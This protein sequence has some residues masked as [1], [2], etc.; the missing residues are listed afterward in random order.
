MLLLVSIWLPCPRAWLLLMKD[1]KSLTAR[2]ESWQVGS[3]SG[4]GYLRALRLKR[5]RLETA[6]P[7]RC[8]RLRG[9]ADLLAFQLAQRHDELAKLGLFELRFDF[10]LKLNE[11][12]L[13]FRIDMALLLKWAIR[14]RY[15][16]TL[17]RSLFDLVDVPLPL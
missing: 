15:D 3:W 14:Q 11:L 4:C 9:Q 17:G 12:D 1:C 7:A 16:V 2:F 8:D 6:G 13:D 10:F 5:L